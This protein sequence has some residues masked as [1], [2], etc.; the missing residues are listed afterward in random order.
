MPL[1]VTEAD[2]DEVVAIEANAE[3]GV[4]RLVV[5]GPHVIEAPLDLLNYS[6]AAGE[7][8]LGPMRAPGLAG[9]LYSMITRS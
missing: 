2:K 6:L 5:L 9:F 7:S 3:E 8:A 1:V 4:E